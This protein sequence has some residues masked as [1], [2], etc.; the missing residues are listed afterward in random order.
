MKHAKGKLLDN[1]SESWE[2][3]FHDNARFISLKMDE[4]VKDKLLEWNLSEYIPAFEAEKIDKD[5]LFLLDANSLTTLIPLL[6]PRLKIQN[7]LKRLLEDSS[8][9]QTESVCA[10]AD[11]L[12]HVAPVQGGTSFSTL[13]IKGIAGIISS[14]AVSMS[15][16][17]SWHRL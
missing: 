15:K 6:G 14:G 3:E 16:G 4:F 13:G 8:P 12:Q 7:N 2:P 9:K 5:S 10:P 11:K 1:P 17:Q